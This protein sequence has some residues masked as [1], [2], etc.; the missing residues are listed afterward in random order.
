MSATRSGVYTLPLVLM[1]ALFS[2]LS[3][4][5]VTLEG[6][7]TPWLWAASVFM[8]VGCGLLSTLKVDSATGTWVGFQILAGAGQSYLSWNPLV[9]YTD[10]IRL[11]NVNSESVDC[12][13][14]GSAHK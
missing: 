6:H 7:Y 9:V 5:G 11:W 10:A 13:T 14:S 2:L 3:G 4:I 1:T 12:G 8:A